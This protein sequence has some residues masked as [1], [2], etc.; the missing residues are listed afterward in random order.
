MNV[1]TYTLWTHLISTHTHKHIEFEPSQF[2]H[3]YSLPF[4]EEHVQ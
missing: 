4:I 2:F 3:L 1:Y